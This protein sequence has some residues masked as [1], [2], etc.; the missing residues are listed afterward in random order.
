[1]TTTDIY[2]LGA[3]LSAGIEVDRAEALVALVRSIEENDDAGARVRQK[4]ALL[5]RLV[6]VPLY[7]AYAALFCHPSEHEP[8][9]AIGSDY[10]N[11]KE[12]KLGNDAESH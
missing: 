11:K 2:R 10:L 5:D 12:T 8:F 7:D 4:A 3:F 9:G 6:G 1:M